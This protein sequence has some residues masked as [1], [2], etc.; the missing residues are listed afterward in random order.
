M[1]SDLEQNIIDY[2]KNQSEKG[3][4]LLY[5]H[6]SNALYGIIYKVVCKEE[7]AND[8]LQE[9][10]IKIWSKF[11]SFDSEK[12]KLFTW[13]A[14]I[15]RNRSIDY[16]RSKGA[17]Y[18]IQN[19]DSNVSSVDNKS[20]TS[21]NVDTIGV[22]EEVKKLKVEHQEIIELMYFGGY[23]QKEVSEELDIPIGTVKTRSRLAL[24]EL[25]KV[26]K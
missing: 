15:A 21:I 26:F 14:N 7:I 22:K 13:M 25:R 12:G 18:K 5:D 16:L 6:Y 17:K 24:I 1:P 4:E 3:I 11:N 20:S 23:T 8:L 2:L 9:V 19:L 10:F